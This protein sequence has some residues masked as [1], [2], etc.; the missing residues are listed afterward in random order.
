MKSRI[1][2]DSLRLSEDGAAR[3]RSG[4]GIARQQESSAVMSLAELV[5]KSAMCEAKHTQTQRWVKVWRLWGY[6]TWH[7]FAERELQMHGSTAYRYKKVWQRFGIGLKGYMSDKNDLTVPMSKLVALCDIV[8]DENVHEWIKRA[9]ELSNNELV[10]EIKHARTGKVDA[11]LTRFG[12]MMSE[13]QVKYIN[14]V[15]FDI[16]N[17]YGATNKCDAMMT[18]VDLAVRQLSSKDVQFA[19]V[20]TDKKKKKIKAA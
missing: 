9:M 18:M 8:N 4:I 11:V 7:D 17:K 16:M 12:I 10:A 20:E 5:W 19:A 14:K 6:I 3:L 2:D 15:I 1:V 13:T